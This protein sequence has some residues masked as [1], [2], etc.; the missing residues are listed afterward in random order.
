MNSIVAALTAAK[1]TMSAVDSTSKWYMNIWDD[2]VQLIFFFFV[3][4]FSFSINH[5]VVQRFAGRLRD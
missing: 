1:K 3:V 2:T 4:F 5:V